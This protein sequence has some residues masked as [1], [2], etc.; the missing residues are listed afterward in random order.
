MAERVKIQ[1]KGTDNIPQQYL[2]YAY[3]VLDGRIVACQYVQLACRK[4]LDRFSDDRYIFKVEEVDKV[5]RFISRFKH[6][7]GEYAG[8]P[9]VLL[10]FQIFFVANIYGWWYADNPTRRLTTSV[11]FEVAR[12]NAKSSLISVILLYET[13]REA[14][15][16][17]VI[18]ANNYK[19]AKEIYQITDKYLK[20]VDPKGKYIERYRDNIRIGD[21]RLYVVNGKSSSLDG[22]NIQA[23]VLDEA[24]E[25]RDSS[26]YDVLLS[27]QGARKNPL[28]IIA[29]TAGFNRHGFC[30]QYRSNC[31]E[32]IESKKVDDTMF[33][34]IYTLDDSDDWTDP[35]VWIK[36]NPS[37][38][39][40][41]R[42]EQIESFVGKAMNN[43][44][45][46]LGVKTKNLNLWLDSSQSWI[47][48]ELVERAMQDCPKL[49]DLNLSDYD[50]Y[51]VSCGVDLA[52]VS[53]LTAVSYC[54]RDNYTDEYYFYTTAYIPIDTLQDN[55]N[56]YNYRRWIS[57]GYLRTTNTNYTDYNVILSDIL[58]V[59]G[60]EGYIRGVYYDS[61]NATQLT[62]SAID[63]GLPMIP[64]SQAISSF[65]RPTKTLESLLLQGKVHIERNP[66]VQW[67][68]ANV[69]IKTDH[70]GN[71]KPSK[72]TKDNGSKKID[73]IIAMIQALA[74]HLQESQSAFIG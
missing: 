52:S 57:E 71:T 53:D 66:L 22:L 18:S 3:D 73:P 64:Y 32:V 69:E 54:V 24:H 36:S 42:Y 12:K 35:K 17:C 33:C 23:Y 27:S 62:I 55:E 28:A 43:S 63:A 4:Y 38:G 67:C 34:L 72:S 8:K 21:R 61:Y 65:N 68:F 58:A 48:G 11:Y 26:L 19:Q 59:H 40:A 60:D 39:E 6:S 50:R 49:S 25:Q 5:V 20:T 13:M 51:T 47:S 7:D 15:S 10:P 1:Y 9:F 46:A 44:T 56:E 74:Y 30:Y 37:L 16:Q 45:L 31:I 29:T 2:Q 14:G 70:N 41:V